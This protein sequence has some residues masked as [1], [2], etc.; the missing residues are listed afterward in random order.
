M[1]EMEVK[2]TWSLAW[3]LFW[4]CW[5]IGLGIYAVFL[6]IILIIGAATLVPW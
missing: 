6:I 5:L 4:R 2:V 1:A 3:G